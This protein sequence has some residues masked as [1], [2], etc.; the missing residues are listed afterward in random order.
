MILRICLFISV[1]IS[2]CLA[3]QNRISINI[4]SAEAEA[5]YIWR[6]LQDI[7]FFEENNY[8]LSLPKHSLIDNLIDS[9]KAGNF[10]ERH[11]E[12]IQSM[13][14]D[15]IYNRDDY[16]LGY[17]K[18]EHRR[19]L[20]N[21]MINEIDDFD[22]NWPVKTFKV[23]QINLTLYGPGG[24]Y[25]PDE[26]SILIY[27]SP[28]GM[29]KNYDEPHNTIIH[30]VVHIGIEDSIVRKYDLPH[31]LKERIVDTFVS[32]NFGQYLPNYKI[33]EMGDKRIDPFLKSVEE[34]KN[35]DKIV[36]KIME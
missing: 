26:G 4:P 19:D 18:L 16:L 31:P 27:T 32:L 24:S 7:S 15:S 12:L 30:E 23:Y 29:F 28:V 33:Q 3:G 9:V 10:G 1:L 11:Y 13:M 17:K 8:Q 20:M 35:L 21:Q 36:R 34:F 14:T 6:T 2:S 25:D 22:L 5:E